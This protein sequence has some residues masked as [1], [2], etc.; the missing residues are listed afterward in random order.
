MC[1][2]S[3]LLGDGPESATQIELIDASSDETTTVVLASAVAVP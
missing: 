1:T 2:W 3:K